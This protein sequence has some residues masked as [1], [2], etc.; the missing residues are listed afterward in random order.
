MSEDS[1]QLVAENGR[2]RS[3]NT[4]LRNRVEALEK[5]VHRLEA[6]LAEAQS[7]RNTKTNDQPSAPGSSLSEIS[8]VDMVSSSPDIVTDTDKEEFVQC[9]SPHETTSSGSDRAVVIHEDFESA[10]P[11]G[12]TRKK[13]PDNIALSATDRAPPP[14]TSAIKSYFSSSLADDCV[15]LEKEEVASRSHPPIPSGES[16]GVAPTGLPDLEEDDDEGGWDSTW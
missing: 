14:D 1:S 3:E 9:P 16:G 11:R 7:K 2:L 5:D 10:K 13:A 4:I 6:A 12:V 8:F 15:S